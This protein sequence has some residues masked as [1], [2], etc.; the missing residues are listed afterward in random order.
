M[1]CDYEQEASHSKALSESFREGIQVIGF[2]SYHTIGHKHPYKSPQDFLQSLLGNRLLA[3]IEYIPSLK[4][5]V[6]TTTGIEQM[7]Q[8]INHTGRY[9]VLPV[10]ASIEGTPIQ[11]RAYFYSWNDSLVGFIY[12][13][14]DMQDLFPAVSTE[15]IDRILEPYFLEMKMSLDKYTRL[16]NENNN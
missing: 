14:I 9:A 2:L 5:C 15:E 11:N 7:L 10:Y 13:K 16:L 4:I 1:L 8:Q 3:P 6:R 12:Q